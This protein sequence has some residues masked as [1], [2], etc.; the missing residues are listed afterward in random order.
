MIKLNKRLAL[1][2]TMILLLTSVLPSFATTNTKTV[3]VKEFTQT[4][5]TTLQIPYIDPIQ[6]A[7]N[8][9]WVVKEH[10]LIKY[11][12]SAITKE[13]SAQFL[14][15]VLRQKENIKSDI[16]FER[17]L[18]LYIFDNKDIDKS[19]QRAVYTTIMSGFYEP[20]LINNL[21]KYFYPK[22]KVSDSEMKLMMVRLLDKSKRHF[23]YHS[24]NLLGDVN[25]Y[26]SWGISP[27]YKYIPPH[28]TN[29]YA[30]PKISEVKKAMYFRDGTPTQDKLLVLRELDEDEYNPYSPQFNK[31]YKYAD[32][33]K[34]IPVHLA[35]AVTPEVAEEYVKEQVEEQCTDAE[36][37]INA[38]FNISY[39]SL[40][41]DLK[42]IKKNIACNS[43]HNEQIT[44]YSKSITKNKMEIKSSFVTDPTTFYKGDYLNIRGRLY[45]KI[46]SPNGKV[47][48]KEEMDV[49]RNPTVQLK[50]NT[51]YYTDID[52]RVGWFICTGEDAADW[53][54]DG[55]YKVD[56]FV[57]VSDIYELIEK[58]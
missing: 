46:T 42:N 45:F 31:Y 16:H 28:I 23:P 56:G 50:S 37:F 54:W 47:P 6:E 27:G 19:Y 30:V 25:E 9:K 58:K 43:K 11:P 51:W 44:E 21:Y 36:N 26:T 5:L 13:Q 15:S 57:Q 10:K 4:L 33:V 22:N 32:Y 40:A 35:N 3:T 2:I 49:S 48:F 24:N 20:K 12:N 41:K 53:T 8:Q 7:I 17:L 52:V 39:K 29:G 55:N 1:A 18:K 34:L 38:Y 14:Y